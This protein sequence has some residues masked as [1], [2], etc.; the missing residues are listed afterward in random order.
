MARQSKRQQKQKQ[1]QEQEKQK[2][3][4]GEA[5][6]AAAFGQQVYGSAGTQHA[7]VGT[8]VIDAKYVPN[9]GSMTGGKRKSK[10]GGNIVTDIAVPAILLTANQLYVRRKTNK[11]MSKSRRN[12]RKNK[13]STYRKRR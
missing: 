3:Q 6:S 12:Y 8:N 4:G 10:K 11:F 2:Q 5:G 1:Q 9:C 7:Q 13:R